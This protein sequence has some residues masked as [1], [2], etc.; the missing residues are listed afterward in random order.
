MEQFLTA[1]TKDVDTYWT[2][3]FEDSGLPEPKVSYAWIPAGQDR[4]ERVRRRER[5]AGR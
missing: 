1:V 5:H 3:V 2:Q 4:G